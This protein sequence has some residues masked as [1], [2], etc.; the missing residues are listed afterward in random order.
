MGTYACKV[1]SV[2][3]TDYTEQNKLHECEKIAVYVGSLEPS[4]VWKGRVREGTVVGGHKHL[5]YV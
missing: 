2:R 1:S 3:I 5:I 4:F